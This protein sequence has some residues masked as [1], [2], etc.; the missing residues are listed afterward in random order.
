MIFHHSLFHTLHSLPF[1]VYSFL[2][3]Q[4]TGQAVNG[5][6]RWDLLLPRKVSDLELNSRLRG[7]FSPLWSG[8]QAI[9]DELNK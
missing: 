7:Q 8:N 3:H 9:K 2:S 1:S 6:V 5:A 4:G